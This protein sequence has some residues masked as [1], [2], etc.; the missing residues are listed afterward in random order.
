MKGLTFGD[1]EDG[2]LA[3]IQ[4]LGVRTES[5]FGITKEV[6]PDLR[7]SEFIHVPFVPINAATRLIKLNDRHW[8]TGG[9]L[10][11]VVPSQHIT[12]QPLGSENDQYVDCVRSFVWTKSSKLETLPENSDTIC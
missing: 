11:P 9:S 1:F 2:H 3:E 4:L 5:V 8:R 12:V 6:F 10:L 7:L